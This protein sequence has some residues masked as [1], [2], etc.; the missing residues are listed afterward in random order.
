MG[1]YFLETGSNQ[2]ND[3]AGFQPS[4]FPSLPLPS[5]LPGLPRRWA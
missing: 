4:P 3:R 5:P 2:K 1:I